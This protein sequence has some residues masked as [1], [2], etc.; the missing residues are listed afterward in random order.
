MKTS[1]TPQ[2][3]VAIQ[4]VG[5]VLQQFGRLVLRA[6][7][8]GLGFISAT[9]WAFVLIAH[10]WAM[11]AGYGTAS[12]L[13]I[14]TWLLVTSPVMHMQL[15]LIVDVIGY[16][17]T[18]RLVFFPAMQRVTRA[19]DDRERGEMTHA[20]LPSPLNAHQPV[21][22]PK[23]TR[24]GVTLF[25]IAADLFSPLSALS[26]WCLVVLHRIPESAHTPHAVFVAKR[27]QRAHELDA[28]DAAIARLA[29]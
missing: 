27:V 11:H 25:V 3:V 23:N 19:V 24:R 13:A 21:A 22:I 17:V 2:N 7:L 12:L 6:Y 18:G 20:L 28:F 8:L 10:S 16:V 29:R 26:T 15:M 4:P 9:F 5:F 14:G 1:T